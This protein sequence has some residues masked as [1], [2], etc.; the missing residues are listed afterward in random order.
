MT[1]NFKMIACKVL[2]RELYSLAYNCPNA[3]DI[4]W[5]RQKLHETPDRLRQEVQGIIDRIDATEGDPCEAILLGY[6]LCS[7]G[8]VGLRS[9]RYPLV[10]PRAHDCITFLL[11]SKERYRQEFEG[12]SGGIYWYSPGW[13]EQCQQPSRERLEN[14]YRDYV[15]RFGEDNAQYLMEMEQ[16]WMTEYH[17]AI[18]V[19]WPA[20][21]RPDY[22]RYTQECAEFLHWQCHV[23]PGDDSL[24]RALMAGQWDK[25]RFVIVPP[26]STVRPSYGPDIIQIDA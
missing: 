2:L 11:G 18:Y 21:H 19:D 8:I 4:T 3:V 24:M 16:R 15:E 5:L 25:E 13:I 6:G 20:L 14:T 17:H 1:R 26:G 22:V 10:I 12:H 23:L 9:R 7:N